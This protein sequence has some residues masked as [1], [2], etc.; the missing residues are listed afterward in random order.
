LSQYEYLLNEY[1]ETQ[2]LFEKYKQEFYKVCPKKIGPDNTNPHTVNE[3]KEENST[4]PNGTD[5]PAENT[6]TNTQQSY[7]CKLL[8]KLYKKLSLKTH[9]DKDKTN[10]YKNKFEE[11]HH[12]YTKKDF[13]KLVL[14]SRE[15]DVNIDSIYTEENDLNSTSDISS[16]LENDYTQL[17]EKSISTMNEKIS[18]IKSTLAWNW[19]LGN[20]EQKK[21]LRERFLF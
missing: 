15:L 7:I 9:P 12:A 20:D 5:G 11:V 8:G 13:L 3:P 19:A 17:F 4:G 18:Q 14:L 6:E 10:K 1:E 2:Y 16:T 21:Q